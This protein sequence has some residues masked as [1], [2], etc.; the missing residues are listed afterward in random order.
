MTFPSRMRRI[1]LRA[2]CARRHHATGDVADAAD[3]EDLPDLD[4]PVEL[5]ADFRFE[6]ADR[7]FFRSSKIS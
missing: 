1:L 5:L 2:G 6:H 4:M 7:D 3:F